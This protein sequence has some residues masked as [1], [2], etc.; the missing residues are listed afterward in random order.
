LVFREDNFL[1]NAEMIENFKPGN[2][3]SRP[4][5]LRDLGLDELEKLAAELP[6]PHA[7]AWGTD[8][9]FYCRACYIAFDRET[10]PVPVG[11]CDG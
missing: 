1:V 5:A 4:S 6:G 11:P 10:D 7:W 3:A 8:D 2:G 9:V